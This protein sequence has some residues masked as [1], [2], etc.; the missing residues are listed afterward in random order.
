[1]AGV[2]ACAK[3]GRFLHGGDSALSRFQTDETNPQGGS[4]RQSVRDPAREGMPAMQR[5]NHSFSG[6]RSRRRRTKKMK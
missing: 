1:M 5:P 4:A 3:S 2:S 6:E